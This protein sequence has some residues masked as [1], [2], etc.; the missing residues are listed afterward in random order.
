MTDVLDEAIYLTN[1]LTRKKEKFGPIDPK[2]VRI[3]TCGPTVYRDIHI[4][5]L[6]TYLMADILKRVLIYNGYKVKHIKNI[7]DVGHMRTDEEHSQAID[8][9]I[10]EALKRGKTPQEIAKEY[11]DQFMEDEK[12][13]NILPADIF[14]KATEHIKEMIEI[15]KT[16]LDK[17]F[18]YETA[19]A[20][21]FN[22]KKFDDY[23]KLSGNTLKKMIQL[24]EAV[25]VS[26]ETDKKDSADF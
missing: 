2:E 7:T 10:V 6:R 20:V 17:G 5:N 18:A 9:V 13:L 25:R 1:T 19:G 11:T 24:L 23:G 16:L 21:Y 22:V 8:P 3:Y 15:T 14:P 4:G 12:R 26:S